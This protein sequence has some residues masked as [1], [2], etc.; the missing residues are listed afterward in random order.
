MI[1]QLAEGEARFDF[2]IQVRTSPSMSVE[3]SMVEW[4]ESEAPFHKVATIIIPRQTFA[5]AAQ[6][7]FG[8][9]PSF[10]PWHALPDHRP[11]GAINRVRRVVYEEISKLRHALNKVPHQEPT[12]DFTPPVAG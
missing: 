1:A 12:A 9:N 5:T 11:L 4:K 3:N 7:E 2:L 8:E 10:S 6:D